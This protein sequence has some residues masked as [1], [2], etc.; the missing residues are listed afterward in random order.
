MEVFDEDVQLHGKWCLPRLPPCHAR[1][2]SL[3]VRSD[4]KAQKSSEDV[5]MTA[6]Y[7]WRL[8]R[9]REW[10]RLWL[11]TALKIITFPSVL[12]SSARILI[13]YN[14]LSMSN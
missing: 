2:I 6:G 10:M 9:R 4:E 7:I 1:D 3:K 5:Q 14:I 11:G 12:T 13:V 8:C